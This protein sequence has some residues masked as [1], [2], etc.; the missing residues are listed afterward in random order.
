[1][2]RQCSVSTLPSGQTTAHGVG[3]FGGDVTHVHFTVSIFPP[4]ASQASMAPSVMRQ[5]GTTL[6]AWAAD[7]SVRALSAMA[8]I[9][10]N[11]EIRADFR[12]S[13]MLTSPSCVLPISGFE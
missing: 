13:P 8:M 7:G 5:A 11:A 2:Q 10:S 9:A 1:M 6:G 3:I 4:E 12:L